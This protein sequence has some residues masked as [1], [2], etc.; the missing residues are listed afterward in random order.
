MLALLQVSKEA[1]ALEQQQQLALQVKDEQKTDLDHVVETTYPKEDDMEKQ[2]TNFLMTEV[3]K[4]PHPSLT[5]SKLDEPP[6]I[7]QPLKPLRKEST[8]TLLIATENMSLSRRPGKLRT[9]PGGSFVVRKGDN[10]SSDI[11]SNIRS[12]LQKIETRKDGIEFIR[13]HQDS[14]NQVTNNITG[15][16]RVKVCSFLSGKQTLLKSHNPTYAYQNGSNLNQS[17]GTREMSEPY[18]SREEPHSSTDRHDGATFESNGE[19]LFIR[20]GVLRKKSKMFNGSSIFDK[21]NHKPSIGKPAEHIGIMSFGSQKED[22]V[23]N[24]SELHNLPMQNRPALLGLRLNVPQ[25]SLRRSGSHVLGEVSKTPNNF[26]ERSWKLEGNLQRIMNELQA[27]KIEAQELPQI[28]AKARNQR[29]LIR[30][31]TNTLNNDK[32]LIRQF[33]TQNLEN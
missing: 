24:K 15:G 17:T 18:G 16:A 23:E 12:I 19:K 8:K 32:K 4:V 30:S 28:Q 1:S 10:G 26:G 2:E 11:I 21:E 5:T 3:F 6:Q 33:S 14:V 9:T 22:A 13:A 31:N 20:T 27:A 29:F 25:K 7:R